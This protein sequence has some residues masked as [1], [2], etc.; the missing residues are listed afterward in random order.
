MNRARTFCPAK[1]RVQFASHRRRFKARGDDMPARN[2]S[3]LESESAA[4]MVKNATSSRSPADP[5]GNS[6]TDKPDE[7]AYWP[8]IAT[9]DQIPGWL[10]DNDYIVGGHPMPTYSYRRSFRLWRCLHMETM[11]IWTHL[12]GSAAFMVVG[13]TLYNDARASTSLNLSMGDKF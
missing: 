1:H 9:K 10:R 6:A 8:K 7:D 2:T 12:L 11:N 4:N 13:F 5:D 3:S